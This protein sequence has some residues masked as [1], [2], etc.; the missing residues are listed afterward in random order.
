MSVE[1]DGFQADTILNFEHIRL[2]PHQCKQ[3]R[4][5]I[6]IKK[7]KYIILNPIVFLNYFIWFYMR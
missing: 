4:K 3:M 7:I 5:A 6:L 2:D 1:G